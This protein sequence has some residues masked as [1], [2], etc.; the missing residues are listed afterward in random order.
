MAQEREKLKQQFEK[1][2]NSLNTAQK[3]AVDTIDGPVLVI[4][5]PGT[6]KTQI[7]G[8]RI[9]RILE[10][11][12]V[13][14]NNILCLTYTDAGAVKMRERLF[15]KFIGSEAY[16]VEIHTFH[17][18]C[19]KVIQENSF[20]FDNKSLRPASELEIIEILYELIDDLEPGNPIRKLTG[21]VYYSAIPLKNLF[22]TIKKEHFVPKELIKNAINYLNELPELPEFQFKTNRGEN[23]KGNPNPRLIKDETDK[24]ERLVAAI[25][26]F[27][28]YNQK[29]SCKNLYD[30]DDMINWVID[31]FQK[32][33]TL[34]GRYQEQFQYILVDEYQDT[35]GS[36]NEILYL[37]A[38]FYDNPNVFAV[39]DDDQSIYSFQGANT[40]RIKEFAKKYNESLE[41]V[42]LSQ[43][44]RSSQHILDASK[45]LIEF[46]KSRLI[47]D[48]ELN[49]SYIQKEGKAL[50]K[51]LVASN[52]EFASFPEK[53]NIR[54]Y[55]NVLQEEA[56]IVNEIHNAY[57]NGEHLA[58]TAIIYRNHKNAE[59]IVK[60]FQKYGIP[61]NA[62]LNYNVLDE[63]I[64]IQLITI[65][66][67]LNEEKEKPNNNES[68]LFELMHYPYFGIDVRDISLIARYFE[69]NRLEKRYGIWRDIIGSSEKMLKMGLVSTG[70][71]LALETNLNKWHQQLHS[72]TIQVL[73]ENILNFGGILHYVMNHPD[74]IHLLECINSFFDFMKDECV[75]KPEM[76]IGDFLEMLKKMKKHSI[77]ID[78]QK[79]FNSEK[80]V[81]LVTGHSS[82]GLEFEKVYLIN[83]NSENWEK[84]RKQSSMFS[85]K[86]EITGLAGTENDENSE[87]ERRLFYVAMTRAKKHLYISY[88]MMKFTDKDQESATLVRSVFVSN[89][90]DTYPV[91]VQ[92]IEVLTK[93]L[94]NIL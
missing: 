28:L 69:D 32:H 81:N 92:K 40:E 63:P 51:E 34:L 49:N 5:G 46:N 47:Y 62:K 71:I 13:Y 10:L 52:P 24:I 33:D 45:S 37:L 74:K 87:E 39:G 61:F 84:K 41:K 79:I 31:A 48:D 75:K 29:M 88:P 15:N 44:Y 9:A 55:Q 78:K 6:G 60:L 83:C 7:L 77:K 90:L 22:Q 36:Q 80:G 30:F 20:Y 1:E 91:E 68:V 72:E 94:L 12:D 11:D 65:L 54:A 66:N 35:N 85:L 58:D 82:K 8:A 25:A 4:A 56:H 14:P 70:K 67:Y 21:D 50:S 59:N 17:S 3:K 26:L 23:K 38:S 73:F 27:D 19:N 76:K 2:Y 86:P 89:M 16:K 53:I 93:L 43:N 42:V 18:F 64:I 57:K